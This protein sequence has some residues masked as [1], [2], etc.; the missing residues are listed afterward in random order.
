MEG[1]N[2]RYMTPNEIRTLDPSQI[3]SLKMTTG[4]TVYVDESQT[5]SGAICN[6][7]RMRNLQ[8]QNYVLRAKKETT[9]QEGEHGEKI[10]ENVEIDVQAQPE[11]G[12]NDQVLRGPD[13]MV[14]LN[15][16]LTKD[17][18]EGQNQEQQQIDENAN[19]Q[20]QE[21]NNEQY[22]ENEGM[23]QMQTGEEQYVQ[24]QNE[25]MNY[26]ENQEQYY[27]QDY[28]QDY[29]QDP[30]YYPPENQNDPNYPSAEMNNQAV[31]EQYVEQGYTD[32]YE[33]AQ[34]Q[35]NMYPS[36]DENENQQ[37]QEPEYQ[38]PMNVPQ[39]SQEKEQEPPVEA[40]DQPPLQ[41]PV[42]Y[43]PTQQ[44]NQLPI[45]PPVSKPQV[46]KD[47]KGYV[48]KK[49]G[50]QMKG[51]GL[52]KKPYP[53]MGKGFPQPHGPHGPQRPMGHPAHGPMM[54][55][56]PMRPQGPSYKPSTQPKKGPGGKVIV[57]NPVGA[58]LNAVHQ[59]MAPIAMAA[60]GIKIK[61]TK[62]TTSNQGAQKAGGQQRTTFRA[63]P[64]VYNASYNKQGQTFSSKYTSQGYGYN[65]GNKKTQWSNQPSYSSH[66]YGKGNSYGN[67]RTQWSNQ[68]SY[69][70]Q[71]YGKGNNYKFHE[72]V[73][74]SDNSKSYVVVK[75]GGETVS[76]DQ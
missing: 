69:G 40:F 62:Q 23:A 33:Q 29:N 14:F 54:P 59:V 51:S 49:P 1:Y 24:E 26:D 36:L 70:S 44:P 17:Q 50:Y 60:K 2:V 72:I 57:I 30:N 32:Q 41:E 8:N 3:S 52:P 74:T 9:V 5:C 6:N 46:A 7:C 66:T 18:E 35:E 45:K 27:D 67:K 71:T 56:G 55:H 12:N 64:N 63:R 11:G 25:E 68:P 16:I 22:N 20:Q 42:Q 21:Q 10:E 37:Y 39:E 4:K 13:G 58:M 31:Q 76:Y 28:N 15:D 73:E 38:P 47:I 43:P 61:N 19:Y 34:G 48:P 53:P 65:Y 75:K